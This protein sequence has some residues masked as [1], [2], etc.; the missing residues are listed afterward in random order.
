MN[1]VCPNVPTGRCS[2]RPFEDASVWGL[3]K[4]RGGRKW[5]LAP[6]APKGLRKDSITLS[7]LDSSQRL[8]MPVSLS[9]LPLKVGTFV[10][11]A[12]YAKLTTSSRPASV[13]FH[14]W[15][16]SRRRRELFPK[17]ARLSGSQLHADLDLV[18]WTSFFTR[19]VTRPQASHYGNDTWV[20]ILRLC[21]SDGKQQKYRHTLG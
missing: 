13:A 10:G 20:Y 11:A 3:N 16:M 15:T 2:G 4:G 1:K 6:V 12:P 17:S 7:P 5:R 21:L 18:C 19:A 9:E 14:K 8:Q